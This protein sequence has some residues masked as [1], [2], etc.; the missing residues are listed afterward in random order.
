MKWIKFRQTGTLTLE[1]RKNGI[2]FEIHGRGER[3]H[4][5]TTDM[6]GLGRSI[7]TAGHQEFDLNGAKKFCQ[8]IAAGE[9]DVAALK[10]KYQA[11]DIERERQ[12]V[13]RNVGE[14]KRF[15]AKLER[16]GLSY[17]EFAE[18]EAEAQELSDISRRVLVALERGEGIPT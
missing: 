18:L 2:T 11:E 16:A 15:R 3:F 14:A 7:L 9:I 13:Q 10:A 6:K 17:R 5:L 1:G 4:V 8:R 12:E